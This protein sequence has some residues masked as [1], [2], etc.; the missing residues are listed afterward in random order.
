MVEILGVSILALLDSGADSSIIG[1]GCEQLVLALGIDTQNSNSIVLTADGTP[2]VTTK[3]VLLPVRYNNKCLDIR[4]IL[5]PE[6]SKKMILGIDFFVKFNIKI[7]AC[8]SLQTEGTTVMEKQNLSAEQLEQLAFAIKLFDGADDENIG[9][10]DIL[11]HHI[12]TGDSL[13]IK[14]RHYPVSPYK[15]KEMD[16][17]FNRMLKLGVI[18][19]SNSPWASPMVAVAKSNGKIRLCLDCRK[20]NDVTKKDSYPV[21]YITRILGNIRGTNYLSKIDLKDA[22]WQIG[23][24]E[25]SKEKTAFTIPGRGLFQFRVMPFGLSNAVQTQCRLMDAVLGFDMEPFVFAYLDDIVIATDSFE[26]HI[27]CLKLTAERLAKAGLK[28]NINK[29]EFCIPEIKYLGY[30]LNKDGLQTDKDK[31]KCISEFPT[32]TNVKEVRRFMGMAGWYRRFISDF[33]SITAPLTKLTG[34]KAGKFMWNE[35][36]ERAFEVTKEALCSSPVLTMPNFSIP[37]KIHA[38]ASDVGIG[39]VLVQGE[40]SEER[41]IAFHSHK[42]TSAQRKYSTT[43][44]ECLAV[45]DAIEHFRPFIDGVHFT[46]ITDH[47]SLIWLRNLKNPVGRLG[48]WILKLQQYNFAIVHRKGKFN[49]V[50][51]ALSRAFVAELSLS[52]DNW[53]IDEWYEDLKVKIVQKPMKYSDFKVEGEVIYKHC[54]SKERIRGFEYDWLIVVPKNLREKILKENHDDS[55]SAHFGFYKTISKIQ[56]RYYW[57]KMRDDISTYV[58]SCDICKANKTPTFIVRHKMG[59]PKPLIEPWRVIAVD[60]LGPLP[61]SKRGNNYILVILD[62]FSKF[63]VLTPVRNADTKAVIKSLKE[64]VFCKFGV[65]EILISDN[66]TPFISKLFEEF[67]KEKEI[68]QWKNA[69]YHPQNN[70]AE[71]P[72]KIIAAA[73]RSYIG[74]DHRLWDAEISSIATAINSSKHQS[75]KFTPFFINFG[76]EMMLSGESYKLKDRNKSEENLSEPP[77]DL[78]D[79]M[80]EVRERVQ[81]N[82]ATAYSK[83]SKGYNLRSR[84]ISFSPGEVV[85][86]KNF[87]LSDATKKY[88]AKLAPKYIKCKV[89]QKLGIST[90]LLEELDGKIVKNTYSTSDLKK[91]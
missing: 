29:S 11:K 24:D 17:E 89:R 20:L 61:R 55:T 64:Q 84:T 88:S 82:L 14:Q 4:F 86:R 21:P 45:I 49:I 67:L 77:V 39:G 42:L 38:D 25:S 32:P 46:V 59:E 57:P 70:P 66:G 80:K 48:R 19:K 12:D 68:K 27:H 60:Y 10:T 1:K 63:I 5:L 87:A 7:K 83:Y 37:F 72:N 36:A 53:S 26:R 35:D 33:S 28:I 13:P 22:F 74:D 23:L 85:W 34:K 50:P 52:K 81:E 30:I 47:S 43:E 58:K 76:R 54:E 90:Y 9:R 62:C 73:I 18:E 65:P 31:V 2:H 15:Q 69:V 44:R 79:R 78:R 91:N 71:R 75:S 8:L 51:D 40:G 6:L 41:V 56:A 3:Q 16:M